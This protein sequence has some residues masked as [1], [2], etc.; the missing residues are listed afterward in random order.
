VTTLVPCEV[1][2]LWHDPES[3]DT[4]YLCVPRPGAVQTIDEPIRNAV[5][6]AGRDGSPEMRRVAVWMVEAVVQP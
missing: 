3:C 2:P 6:V 1:Q 5:E 4:P